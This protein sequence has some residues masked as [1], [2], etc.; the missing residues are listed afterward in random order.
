MVNFYGLFGLVLILIG[1]I[2]ETVLVLQEN[3]KPLPLGFAALYGIGSLFLAI[4]SWLLND[5]VFILLNIIATL[6]AI[7]HIF[8]GLTV[9]RTG[10]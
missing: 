5:F 9:R 7:A 4:H 1:W 6:I 10:R 2:Y 8:L 3:K